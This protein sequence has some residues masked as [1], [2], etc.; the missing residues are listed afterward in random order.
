MLLVI[1]T[2]SAILVCGWSQPPPP[3]PPPSWDWRQ[4]GYVGPVVNEANYPVVATIVGAIENHWARKN[5]T[6]TT[7]SMQQV[8]RRLHQLFTNYL[9]HCTA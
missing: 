4:Y 3:P 8:I 1:A 6:F 2:L 9:P 5:E 7:L